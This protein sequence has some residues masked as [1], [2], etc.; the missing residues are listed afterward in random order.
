MPVP[1]SS[2]L[3]DVLLLLEDIIDTIADSTPDQQFS[4]Q[5]L[6]KLTSAF[7]VDAG[8][9]QLQEPKDDEI[10]LLAHVGMS[11]EAAMAAC[12]LT[13][14]GGPLSGV[15]QKGQTRVSPGK[16]TTIERT[17]LNLTEPGCRFYAAAPLKARAQIIGTIGLCSNI[18]SRFT[19]ERLRLLSLV[20]AYA[21]IAIESIYRLSQRNEE[22]I[23]AQFVSDVSEKQEFL[24]ALSHELQTPLTALI[25][26]TGLLIEELQKN[27]QG[28]QIRLAQN[29]ARSASS[30]QNRLTELIDL[31]R[32]KTTR[33]QIK[34]KPSTSRIWCRK[35]PKRYHHW[36][37][38]KDRHC[39]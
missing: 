6:A 11:S 37:P 26:S 33:F 1:S 2:Q 5:L 25:A 30:L 15:L 14:E 8:W 36:S 24:D 10:R 21:G 19:V 39:P 27:P 4:D 28:T 31:S 18:R 22:E 12:Q 3:G 38:Q 16:S 13:S 29:I 23:G 9:I 17:S 7:D 20:G 35:L 32:A 34:K